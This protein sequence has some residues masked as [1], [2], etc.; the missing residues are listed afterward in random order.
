M[1]P[2][3]VTSGLSISPQL[4][5]ADIEAAKAQGFRSIIVNRPDGE[6]AGQPTIEEMR[7]AASA[8]G[9]GFAAIPVTPGKASV[10]D[11]ARFDLAIRTLEGPVIA[12]CRT[13]VRA[14]TLWALSLGSSTAPDLLLQTLS[15]AGYDLSAM[16]PR[17]EALYKGRGASNNTDSTQNG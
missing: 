13:G 17:L 3:P 5:I 8:A 12:Y 7:N 10:E 11:A 6:E 16:K 15:S 1:N 9:L 2:K 14:A 4:S